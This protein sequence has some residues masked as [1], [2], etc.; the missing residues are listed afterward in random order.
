MVS[1][2]LENVEESGDVRFGVDVRK[3]QR[4]TN[5]GLGCQMDDAVYL[6]GREQRLE[7][8]AI[9]QFTFDELESVGVVSGTDPIESSLLECRS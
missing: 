6:L 2:S 5:A 3:I 8:L 9:N 1:A 4:V 7:G